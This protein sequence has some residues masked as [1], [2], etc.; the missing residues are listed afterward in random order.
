MPDNLLAG[1]LDFVLEHA[2]D[3]LRE[4]AGCRL[5]VTGGT[6]FVGSWMMESF[7]HANRRLA[8]EA[9]VVVLTRSPDLYRRSHPHIALDPAVEVMQ[10]DVCTVDAA[11]GT[12]DV[13]IHAATPASAKQRIRRIRPECLKSSWMACGTCFVWLRT[14]AEFRSCSLALAQCMAGSHR[15]FRMSTRLTWAALI[16]CRRRPPITRVS[17]WAELMGAIA[18]SQGQVDVKIARLFAFVG[19]YLPLDAHFAIGNFIGDA[20]RGGPIVVQSDGTAVRSYL[21][22]ADMA[23]LAVEGPGKRAFPVAPTMSD[24][25]TIH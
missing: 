1:D 21:Y 5:F 15:S 6:G 20:L 12:V 19:P 10:G 2:R 23:I 22:G 3:D 11:P 7:L 16:R 9:R 24:R 17:V 4:F 13:F 8:R 18:A 25:T 14:R